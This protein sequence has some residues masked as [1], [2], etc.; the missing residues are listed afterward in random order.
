MLPWGWGLSILAI[1]SSV[2]PV[3]G[4]AT[5]TN[6]TSQAINIDSQPL[7]A[8]C[9]LTR[10]GKT[11]GSLVTP[12]Q[13]TVSRSRHTINVSCRK[14]DYQDTGYLLMA[15]RESTSYANV[16]IPFGVGSIVDAT[17]GAYAS[18]PEDIKV[19]LVPNDS[20]ADRVGMASV[21][22]AAA[23]SFDGRYYGTFRRHAI[24]QGTDPITM[25]VQ[26]A[27]GRGTGTANTDTC[28]VPGDVSLVVDPSGAVVGTFQLKDAA[29]HASLIRMTG[30][31]NGGHM[32]ITLARK[33]DASLDK[34][35]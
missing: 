4:C 2:G 29:C 8:Q 13:I 14:T 9:T 25:D 31:I 10:E 27:A 16:A 22:A 15:D 12:G 6:G 35:P 5:V 17:T 23:G 3:G 11:L 30:Q 28:A 34:Q 32:N 7:G 18:Y 19:W 24:L 1:L 33:F 26:V 21:T 20:S